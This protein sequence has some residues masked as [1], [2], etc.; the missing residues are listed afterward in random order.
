LVP[1][2]ELRLLVTEK[3]LVLVKAQVQELVLVLVMEKVKVPEL[4]MEKVLEKG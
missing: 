2:S 1:G 3:A 4:V